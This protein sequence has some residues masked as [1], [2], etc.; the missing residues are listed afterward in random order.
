[1]PIVPILTIRLLDI[2]LPS[3]PDTKKLLLLGAKDLARE[4]K[5]LFDKKKIDISIFHNTE[6]KYSGLQLG[7]Y[8]KSPE[9]TAIGNE[10]V[11]ALKLWYKIFKSKNKKELKNTVV[12]NEK[13]T[14]EFLNYQKKYRINPILISDDMAKELNHVK[15]KFTRHDRLE[16]YVYGN[17][18]RFF[19]HINF[20]H[21][22]KQNFLKINILDLRPYNRSVDVYHR[23]KKTA[24]DITFL[25]NFRLPQT[26]RLGQST[27]VGYG[28]MKHL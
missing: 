11:K 7:N 1:M 8:Q 23:Q 6:V 24:F 5:K 12:I 17:L 21:D 9:W 4:H 28:K 19:T 3:E 18:Q 14:P 2:P 10:A 25:C 26:V 27:A 15:D 20:E 13:Y 16:K 22:K